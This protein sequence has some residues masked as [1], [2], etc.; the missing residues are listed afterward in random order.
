MQT[1]RIAVA[2]GGNAAYAVAADLGRLGHEISMLEHPDLPS[3]LDGTRTRGTIRI[4]GCGRDVEVPI[5]R[6][7]TD[8][9]EA[10]KDAEILFVA[11]PAF[12]HRSF[13]T[14]TAPHLSAGQTVVVFTAGLGGLE[15]VAAARD[16]HRGAAPFTVVDTDT[17]PYTA[18]LTGAGEVTIYVDV[19]L[20]VAGVFPGARTGSIAP[21]LSRLFPQVTFGRDLLEPALCNVNPTI[22]P[23]VVLLNVTQIDC[24]R[25]GVWWIWEVGVTPTVARVIE[26]VDAERLALA[27]AF[28]LDLPTVAEQQWRQGYGPRGTIYESLVGCAALRNI[29]GPNTLDHRFIAED[30]P[31]FLRTWVDLAAAANV[32]CPTMGAVTELGCAMTGRDFWREGRTLASFGLGQLAPDDFMRFL[33][34]GEG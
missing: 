25:G 3:S 21:L 28:G 15:W 16:L 32:R 12:A 20:V 6:T 4:R 9:A 13:A 7:T 34:S 2:G 29:K 30:I 5:R 14:L 1:L 24:S 26:R 23:A 33:M 8:P 18:R 22:H 17:L 10:L 11:V 27:K 31:Y 19:K